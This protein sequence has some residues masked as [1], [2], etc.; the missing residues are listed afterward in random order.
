MKRSLT[1]LLCFVLVAVVLCAC[2]EEPH[3]HTF[4]DTWSSDGANHWHAATC[5]HADE[6]ADVT[7][8]VD[9]NNDGTCDVCEYSGCFH[10]I[11]SDWSSDETNHWHAPTCGHNVPNEDVAAHVDTIF[12]GACDVCGY[13]MYN[14]YTVSIDAEEYIVVDG[15][16]T[17]KE[18]ETVTFTLTVPESAIIKSVTGATLVGEPVKEGNNYV[19]TYTVEALSANTDVVVESEKLSAAQVVGFGEAAI[20]GANGGPFYYE[21]TLVLNIPAAGE[22]TIYSLSYDAQVSFGANIAKPTY[23]TFYTFTAEEA[24]E[25][26]IKTR[27]FSF[28][29]APEDGTFD[30]L[31]VALATVNPVELPRLEGTGFTMPTNMFTTVNVTIPTPGFYQL[32]SN[33]PD[34]LLDD[35]IK[36][37]ILFSTSEANQ[38]FTFTVKVNSESEPTFEFNWEIISLV[39]VALADGI[40]EFTFTPGKY[41]AFS[42]DVTTAGA[43]MFD[44]SWANASTYL[45]NGSALAYQGADYSTDNLQVGATITFYVMIDNES[46]E[47]EAGT[48][49]AGYSH[50]VPSKN[51]NG[52]Y[53]AHANTEGIKNLYEFL[54][55][56]AEVEFTVLGDGLISLDGGATWVTSGSLA[57][58]YGAKV[59][60]LVKSETATTVEV[61][62]EKLS[63]ERELI[64]G[65]DNV[66][67]IIPGKEYTITLEGFTTEAQYKQFFLTFTDANLVIKFGNATVVSGTIYSNYTVTS[68]LS[69]IYNGEGTEAV[70]VTIT[71]SEPVQVSIEGTLKMGAN[72]INPSQ[73]TLTATPSGNGIL[74]LTTGAEIGGTVTFT[75]SI[76][77]G[78]TISIPLQT[79]VD[80]PLSAGQTITIVASGNGYSSLQASFVGT[81]SGGGEGGEGGDVTP[82]TPVEDGSYENPFILDS[83]NTEITANCDAS[84]F[85][86]YSFTATAN[87]VLTITYPTANAWVNITVGNSPVFSVEESEDAA[88]QVSVVAGNT[89][90][91][92]LGVWDA[93]A[94]DP[95]VTLSFE[96]GADLPGEGGGEEPDPEEP[97]EPEYD[98]LWWEENDITITE[99]QI[100]TGSVIYQWQ[101]G[102]AG[103]YTFTCDGFTV[104]VKDAEG[105]VIGSG[106]ITAEAYTVYL[107]EVDL[108]GATAGDYSLNIQYHYPLGTQQ[109][110]IE[111]GLG[112]HTCAFPGGNSFIYYAYT[113]TEGGY[114]TVSTS[115]ATGWLMAGIDAWDLKQNDGAGSS[116]TVYVQAG[117]LCY[118]A[119]ADYDETTCDIPFS[120]S[121]EAGELVPDG[122]FGAPFDLEENNSCAYPGGYSNIYYAYTATADGVL[123]ITVTSENFSWCYGAEQWSMTSVS[124]AS[125][126]VAVAAGETILIGVSSADTEAVQINFTAT[127]EEGATIQIPTQDLVIGNN[128]VS[129]SNINFTY[130]AEGEVTLTLAPGVAVQGPVDYSYS[131]NGDDPIILTKEESIDVSLYTGDILVIYV[132]SDGGYSTLVVSEA[133]GSDVP[134]GPTAVSGNLN[135]GEN[136]LTIEANTYLEYTVNGMGVYTFAWSDNT[137]VVLVNGEAIE[138]GDAVT[139]PNPMLSLTTI[140]IYAP[141]Y[142]AVAGATLTVTPYVAPAI[143][144]VVGEN[145][146]STNSDGVTILFTAPATGTFTVLVGANGVVDNA[147]TF[148]LENESFT[149]D[150]TAGEEV[151]LVVLTMNYEADDITITIVEGTELPDDG[152]EEPETPSETI[153]YNTVI[154][155]GENTLYFSSEEVSGGSADRKLVVVFAGNYTFKG[156][157]FVSAITDANGN[158]I[159]KNADY[160]YTLAVGEYTVSFGMFSIFGTVADHAQALEVT[161]TEIVDEGGEDVGGE[162]VT[163]TVVYMSEK[164]ASGRYLKVTIDTEAGTMTIVRSNMSGGWDASTSTAQYTYSLVDGVVTV[165][166]VSGQ[167]CTCVFDANGAPTSITWQSA[168]FTNFAVQE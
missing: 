126:Q 145:I 68:T 100:A 33:T 9:E 137:L 136:A 43:Q 1:L 150:L 23:A 24:G 22:Y 79:T 108:T 140:T 143:D 55:D 28:N 3:T 101:A 73:T 162:T 35:E 148:A 78:E 147:G 21:G 62:I 8:H 127:F 129:G 59:L 128:N 67:S 32:F 157:L 60:Y 109:N 84:N 98:F 160:S 74:T 141:D 139:V 4:A 70:D 166:N 47:A 51:V 42:Y 155:A 97:E 135:Q 161:Y 75:Y 72:Q 122:T 93:E 96:D 113:P 6:K 53:V 104:T 92:A 48:I 118:I 131:I 37:S 90:I 63:M 29:G 165:T 31:Y 5:E 36:N 121:F 16:L 144:V 44:L 76:S 151:S 99:E 7:A 13:A 85:Y 49:T 52:N 34:I 154:V 19:Y 71:A 89:Y 156:D 66:L 138:N 87:G 167:N 168:T 123:T 107:V 124:G 11:S 152:E 14:V 12:D 114:L 15:T 38:V 116:V 58:E 82:P 103:S 119:V 54:D 115:F 158:T 106:T 20:D 91:I 30:Y 117:T 111:I 132:V 112:D 133:T 18:G 69:L 10:P 65:Q 159:T 56:P 50:Y 46:G 45:W 164:H 41:Y 57:L 26:T 77:G 83:I 142:A 81:G 120:I 130:T 80:I 27:V 163:G 94:V 102:E 88:H 61:Q 149:L 95:V 2:G 25:I 110:P 86:H 39:P 153:D 17:V 134:V 146:I 125:G 40:N 105:N 64:I